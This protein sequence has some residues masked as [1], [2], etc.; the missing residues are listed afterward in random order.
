MNRRKNSR[1]KNQGKDFLGGGQ[2][3]L[4][5]IL[6]KAPKKHLKGVTAAEE[7]SRKCAGKRKGE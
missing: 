5:R 1:K 4:T 7:F 6:K 2:K 3:K